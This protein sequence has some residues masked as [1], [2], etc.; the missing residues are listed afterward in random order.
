MYTVMAYIHMLEGKPAEAED[1]LH[2]VAAS[3]RHFD[4][5]PDYGIRTLQYPVYHNDVILND[6]LGASAVD[7]VEAILDLLGNRELSRIWK[8]LAKDER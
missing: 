7:T 6:S 1:C 3:V 8:G 2:S 4:D 5:A